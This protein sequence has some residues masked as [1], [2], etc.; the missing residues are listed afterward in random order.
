MKE[1][2]CDKLLHSVSTTGGVNDHFHVCLYLKYNMGSD[3]CILNICSQESKGKWE[4]P[5]ILF[6]HFNPLRHFL[7]HPFCAVGLM[8]RWPWLKAPENRGFF[9][10]ARSVWCSQHC[11]SYYA[12]MGAGCVHACVQVPSQQK[13]GADI[14]GKWRETKHKIKQKFLEKQFQGKSFIHI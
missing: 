8:S 5:L 13:F 12:T 1:N 10:P 14:K 9:H 2:S 7:S 11:L 4:N 3:K 6:F